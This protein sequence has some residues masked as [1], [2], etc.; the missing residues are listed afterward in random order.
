LPGRP[1]TLHEL[2][3]GVRTIENKQCSNQ[4]YNELSQQYFCQLRIQMSLVN[5]ESG[6]DESY[7]D[8]PFAGFGDIDDDGDRTTDSSSSED[9]ENSEDEEGSGKNVIQ[10]SQ[11][12]PLWTG[13]ELKIVAELKD[14]WFQGT[15]EEQKNV[16][17][18][19][20]KAL[21]DLEARDAV[22]A[23]KK[24][25]KWLKRRA[26]KRL[27]YGPGNRPSF[28]TVLAY[29]M[30]AEVTE[31]VRTTHGVVPGGKRSPFLGLW[32]KELGILQRTLKTDPDRKKDY[33]RLEASRDNWTTRGPPRERRKK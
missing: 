23:K 9:E 31:K 33:D 8:A 11:G 4:I 29:Y 24:L 22:T 19:G 21:V 26:G 12:V 14:R 10:V 2:I 7:D 6:A 30:E 27:G 15:S 16:V 1:F 20:V 18:E 3:A 13:E 28:Q 32:K 5:Y 17:E 25:I